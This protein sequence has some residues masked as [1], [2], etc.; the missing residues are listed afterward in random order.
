MIMIE[1]GMQN[2][3]S[4]PT[5]GNARVSNVTLNKSTLQIVMTIDAKDSKYVGEPIN[6]GFATFHNSSPLIDGTN[7]V[8]KYGHLAVNALK[9]EFDLQIPQTDNTRTIPVN[10]YDAKVFIT[11]IQSQI[12]ILEMVNKHDEAKHWKTLLE[13]ANELLNVNSK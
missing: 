8:L 13:S 9:K 5:Y 6:N 3:S 7:Y 4:K 11:K 12:E 10:V 2:M 1:K